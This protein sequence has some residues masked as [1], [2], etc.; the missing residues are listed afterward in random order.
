[1]ANQVK[2]QAV[3]KAKEAVTS[4]GNKISLRNEDQPEQRFLDNFKSKGTGL[5]NKV[6]QQA[7][8]NMGDL[9][10]GFLQNM[11]EKAATFFQKAKSNAKEAGGESNEV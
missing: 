11:K 8:P 4:L 6:K 7:K 9:G 10:G 2:Q 1:M 5:F 3:A